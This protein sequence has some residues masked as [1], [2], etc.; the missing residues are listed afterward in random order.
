MVEVRVVLQYI[1]IFVRK[2]LN[3]QD[4]VLSFDFISRKMHV[5]RVKWEYPKLPDVLLQP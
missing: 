2:L 4:N 5:G 3:H 1:P